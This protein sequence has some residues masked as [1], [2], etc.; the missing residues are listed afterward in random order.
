MVVVVA[1]VGEVAAAFD[2]S[3]SIFEHFLV[4]LWVLRLGGR[5]LWRGIVMF[6]Y[7]NP[8]QP[9]RSR[10]ERLGSGRGHNRKKKG[11]GGS[12]QSPPPRHNR[13]SVVLWRV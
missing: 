11:E 4:L 5:F 8:S 3:E 1:A 9:P 7:E 10:L 13:I 2:A 6:E 12:P